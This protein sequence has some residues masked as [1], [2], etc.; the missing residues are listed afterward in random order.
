MKLGLLKA[1]Y[2]DEL[3]KLYRYSEAES[4]FYVILE[5]VEKKNKT[6][7]ILGLETILINTYQDILLE[8]KSGRPVQYIT[9]ES[10]FYSL[11]IYVDEN[12]LIPRPETEE[13]VHWI[14]SEQKVNTKILDIGTGSGCIALAL[15]KGLPSSIISGCD[16]SIKALEVA[17]R[18]ANQNNLDVNFFELNIL[19]DTINQYDIIVSNPPYIAHNEKKKM[20]KNVLDHEPHPALFVDDLDPLLFYKRI[21]NQ[22]KNTN[23]TAYFETSEFYTE[24]LDQWLINEGFFTEWKSDFHGKKRFL[25]ITY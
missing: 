10:I 5:W 16:I 23:T 2:I 14:L 15:K 17:K 19:Y 4:I 22:V 20:H 6:H 13:L 9:N 24:S 1:L 3:K 25:K 12:V 18:N 8:L 7:V 21:A 11:P